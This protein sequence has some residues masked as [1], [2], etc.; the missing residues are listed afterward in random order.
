[1]IQKKEKNTILNRKPMENMNMKVVNTLIIMRNMTIQIIRK[2]EKKWMIFL[3]NLN[4]RKEILIM[5]MNNN[6]N[7]CSINKNNEKNKNK[8]KINIFMKIMINLKKIIKNNKILIKM[9]GIIYIK[10]NKIMIKIK[11]RMIHMKTMIIMIKRVAKTWIFKAFQKI[12]IMMMIIIV[13]MIIEIFIFQYLFLSFVIYE[14]LTFW[15]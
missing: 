1:M 15:E 13:S 2:R 7:I 8:M 14:A 6:K 4:Q 12:L 9:I 3:I 5:I 10:E 11:I